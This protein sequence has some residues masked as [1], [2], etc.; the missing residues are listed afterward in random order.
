MPGS[1]P[2]MA[3]RDP[4]SRLN[5]VDFPTFGRPTIAT[6]GALVFFSVSGNA[7]LTVAQRRLSYTK[8]WL[9]K[10]T[11]QR[12]ESKRE[13][14]SLLCLWKHLLGFL[15][16]DDHRLSAARRMQHH[17]QLLT[18]FWPRPSVVV[19]PV[20]FL[21]KR[22][23]ELE[24]RILPWLK[25]IHM[26]RIVSEE[27]VSPALGKARLAGDLGHSVAIQIAKFRDMKNIFEN[28][29][30]SATFQRQHKQC[31]RVTSVLRRNH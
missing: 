2:T 21:R 15:C 27:V 1:S 22:Q 5:S 23:G 4:I 12:Q 7:A 10:L 28:H 19:L 14:S 17:G 18:A 9:R 26:K 13:L 31:A 30:R 11:A 25:L 8:C 16:F 29:P 24:L 6:R 20:V 3:R